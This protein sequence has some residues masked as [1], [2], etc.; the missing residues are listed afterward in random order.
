M[1]NAAED[2]GLA[3]AGGHPRDPFGWVFPPFGVEV[4]EGP[5]VMHLD[6]FP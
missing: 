5:N 4:F 6:L 1:A 3:A 2:Q